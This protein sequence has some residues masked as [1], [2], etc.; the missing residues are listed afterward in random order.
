MFGGKAISSVKG[1]RIVKKKCKYIIL[2]KFPNFS[3]AQ[4]LERLG[5]NIL[6]LHLLVG[7]IILL[8]TVTAPSVRPRDRK[9]CHI[10]S[11]LHI[12]SGHF[13]VTTAAHPLN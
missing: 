10:I 5:H 13:H 3:N 6:Q 1:L 9:R 4:P 7:S 12:N 11:A 2:N 8:G